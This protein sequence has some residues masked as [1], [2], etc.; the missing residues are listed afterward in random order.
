[1]QGSRR[2]KTLRTESEVDA[3]VNRELLNRGLVRAGCYRSIVPLVTVVK[4]HH[5]SVS[6]KNIKWLVLLI[7][8]IK[9]NSITNR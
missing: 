7:L 8:Y 9:I 3:P 5:S 1:M 6:P 4:I 2:Q